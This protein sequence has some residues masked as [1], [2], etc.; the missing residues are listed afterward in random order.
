MQRYIND[1][2]AYFLSQLMTK[3]GP[4][5]RPLIESTVFIQVTCMGNGRDHTPDNGPFMV[6][7]KRPGFSN[8][9]SAVRGGTTED[10]HGAIPKGL[11]IDAML[12]GMGAATLGL[13]A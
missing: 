10:L 2:P 11:G 8:T 13:L 4:D 6:A 3:M 7:T 9:F 12:R 1:V 5:N